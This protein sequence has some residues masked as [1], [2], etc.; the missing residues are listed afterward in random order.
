MDNNAI[1]RS[2]LHAVFAKYPEVAAVYLFGSRATGRARPDSDYDLAVVATP[3]QPARSRR[4]DILAD[5]AACGLSEVDL[6]FLDGHQHVLEHEAVRLNQVVFRRPEFDPAAFYSRVLR[7]YFD[8]V[9]L[10]NIQRQALKERI[11]HG[12]T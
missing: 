8:V 5:L 11:L 6:T 4:L 1:L 3:G 7:R 2:K 9:P 12:T 10:L